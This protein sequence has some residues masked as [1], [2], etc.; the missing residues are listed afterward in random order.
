MSDAAPGPAPAP[1]PPRRPTGL[2]YWVAAVV[3]IVAV[4]AL[5]FGALSRN[6]IYFRTPTEAVER[7]DTQGETRFR[8]A[9]N[10]VMGS[11]AERRD[12]VRFEVTDG[13]TT[14]AVTHH[15][16]P[17]ELFDDG[18][19]VVC[20]G[21]WQGDRFASDRI[22]IKHGNEYTP[23][24]VTTTL[25]ETGALGPTPAPG[26]ASATDPATRGY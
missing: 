13:S 11:V 24:A 3:C 16:D 2:R 22:M 6:V 15:G 20:E 12:G 26:P 4:G 21:R 18:V 1:A 9:G 14:V 25:P 17:P 19:P 5:V 10:V 8:L 7:K 23:P